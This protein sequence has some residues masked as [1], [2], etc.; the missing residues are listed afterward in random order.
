MCHAKPF[1]YISDSTYNVRVHILY[2]ILL[3]LKNIIEKYDMQQILGLCF[4]LEIADLVYKT[5]D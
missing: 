4:D 1:I 2:T 3:V 5:I